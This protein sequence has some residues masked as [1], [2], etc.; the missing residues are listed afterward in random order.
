MLEAAGGANVFADV[1][2]QSVT[3]STEM[4]LARAPEVII[5]LHYGDAL[6][7]RALDAELRVWNALAVGSGRAEQ[8]R[9]PAD[10]DEFVVP[11]P[12]VVDAAERLRADAASRRRFK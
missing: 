7:T 12:R 1:K 2:Q 11:G 5:E 10:G 9:L 4:V 6:A 3:M 8:P